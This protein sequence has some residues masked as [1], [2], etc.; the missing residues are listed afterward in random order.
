[1][2]C[3]GDI[4]EHPVTGERVRFLETA[5]DNGGERLLLEFEVRPHG[6]VAGE[7][8]HPQQDERFEVLA[9]TMRYRVNGVAHEAGAGTVIDV[10]R[11]TPHIWWNGGEEELRMQV[12]FQPALRTQ[13]FFESFFGLAQQGRTDPRSGMPGL[14]QTAVIAL[15]F[16]PEVQLASP[17]PAVQK[18]VLPPL[19]A[20]GR[21]LGYQARHSYPVRQ[22]AVVV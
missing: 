4:I 20:L 16:A 9:G 7:H 22:T 12:E 14:L 2:I 5:A 10:P 18:V 21:W 17:P 8:V 15:E 3:T 13:D 19:A 11:G 1:M 6:F